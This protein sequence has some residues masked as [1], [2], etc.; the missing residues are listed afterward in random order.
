[1]SNFKRTNFNESSLS[2]TLISTNSYMVTLATLLTA[3]TFKTEAIRQMKHKPDQLQSKINRQ[4]FKQ[5][6]NMALKKKERK[7]DN[8]RKFKTDDAFYK[9]QL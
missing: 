4:L 5:L 9:I 3:T 6:F 8:I 1:M 2:A 7:P